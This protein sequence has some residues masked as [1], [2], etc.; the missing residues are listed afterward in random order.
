L[1]AVA[2]AAA[3]APMQGIVERLYLSV[4]PFQGIL[5]Q[6]LVV[7]VAPAPALPVSWPVTGGSRVVG[8]RQGSA[9]PNFLL[10]FSSNII[11]VAFL[12]VVVDRRDLY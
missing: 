8:S 11:V 1:S 7:I 9:A 6:R 12:F 4:A 10:Y 3:A 5:A 2:I